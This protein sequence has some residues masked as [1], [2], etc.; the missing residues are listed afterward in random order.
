MSLLGIDEQFSLK[1]EVKNLD[2]N[3]CIAVLGSDIGI[4]NVPIRKL[5][6]FKSIISDKPKQMWR[7]IW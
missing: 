2:R 7:K 1:I 3:E 4:E 6:H 5:W